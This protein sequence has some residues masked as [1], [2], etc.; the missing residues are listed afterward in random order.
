MKKLPYEIFKAYDIRGIVGK[1]LTTDIIRIIGHSIGSEARARGLTSIAIGRD[2]R[3]SGSELSQSLAEGLLTS[4]I[5]VLDIGMVA[6][7]MLYLAAHEL[8]DYSGVMVTGSHN[9]PDYNGLKIVLGGE[10]LAAE[11]IQNLRVRIE[12]N[13]LVSGKG[14]YSKHDI[15]EMYLKRI[16]GDITLERPIKIIVDCGNGVA[17]AFAPTLY[18]KLGCEVTEIFCEVDGTFP[19]HHPDPSVPEN[20][21]DLIHAL[22]TTDAEIGL[23]FDGD[24]DRLG[25][26]TKNGN[27]IYPDRQLMLFAADVLSRNPGGKII[28]DVKCTRKLAPWIESHGGKPIMWK[29]GHSFIKAKLKETGALLAGEMSGHIFFKERWYGFDDG[30]Y[31]G[32]RLLELL[33]RQEDCSA[34]LNSIPDSIN[35]PE[36]Q[37]KLKEGENYALIKQL[38]KN[39]RF[40]N[41]ERVVTIDGL[42]VEYKD[43]FGLAR[44]SNTTPVVVL[45]FEAD[46]KIALKRIQ[47]DFRKVILQ[48]K[49]G[50][51]L[52]F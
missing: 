36:L 41:S 26:V 14:S 15:A 10:T 4:G 22:N 21:C 11:S 50:A 48:T 16:I 47:D 35:T 17:G 44:S 30:L 8:C 18:R 33:S 27:I 40:D 13:D 3:L 9:P 25:I 23:A 37:I 34:T 32:A 1:T 51:N 2:G 19:N 29:T 38:Q 42:R 39:A 5:N 45:R 52:P 12:K 20:L 28:F 7:P 46:N 6:T 24:G 49:P 43:G 31:A